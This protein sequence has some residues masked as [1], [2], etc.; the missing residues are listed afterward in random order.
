M[1]YES[2]KKSEPRK[3][4][5]LVDNYFVEVEGFDYVLKL[6]ME[7]EGEHGND[8]FRVIGT[9]LTLDKAIEFLA[10]HNAEAQGIT[11]EEEL[12]YIKEKAEWIN[13]N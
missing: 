10:R 6:G 13:G 3:I 7:Q 12:E 9:F 1:K 5:D 4:Y 2:L 8:L 11:Y